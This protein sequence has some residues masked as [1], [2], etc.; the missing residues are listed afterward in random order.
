VP[1]HP[2]VGSHLTGYENSCENLFVNKKFVIC[3]FRYERKEEERTHIKCVNQLY[4][5]VI[6]IQAKHLYKELNNLLK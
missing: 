2:I 6:K 5:I 1:A 3:P 4:D